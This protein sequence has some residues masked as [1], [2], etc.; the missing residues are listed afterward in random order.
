M[1]DVANPAKP[2][3][4]DAVT[5]FPEMFAALTDCGITRRALEDGV[6]SIG[7]HN[8]RDFVGNNYRTVDDRP[9]GGGPGMVMLPEPLEA[10]IGAAKARQAGAG[11]AKSRVIYLSPQGR[12]LSHERVMRFVADAALADIFR[13]LAQRAA[14]QPRVLVHRDFHSPNLMLGPDEPDPAPGIID[15]QDALDGPISYDIASLALDARTTWDEA[16]QLDWA[17][18]YWEYARAA[19]LPVPDDFARF[20]VDYEW[21]GLQRNLRILGVF[22]RLSHRDGKHHYLD[23]MPRVQAYVRQVA[24]RY[25]VFRPLLRLLDQAERV[26]QADGYSF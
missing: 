14:A 5:I 19:G 20:H 22:A 18:R 21:M 3:V 9:Y 8:P 1:S 23:H 4:I 25:A 11:V 16:R 12:P 26:P 2:F 15:F 10:A 13:L 17:I 24:G 6:W 7:F